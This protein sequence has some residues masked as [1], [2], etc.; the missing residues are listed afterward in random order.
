MSAFLGQVWGPLG[1]VLGLAQGAAGGALPA[2]LA[3]LENAGL[4]ERVRSWVE[5]GENL[6]VTE[7]ELEAMFRPEQL[8]SW[9]IE[10]GTTPEALL[11]VVAKELPDAV[12]RAS[13]PAAE[14][15]AGSAD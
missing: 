4:A 10:A 15:P 11:A 14:I 7:A 12:H 6:P 5:H 2:V 1:Q 3:Q 9:A 13:S 8:N